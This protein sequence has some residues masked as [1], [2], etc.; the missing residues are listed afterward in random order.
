MKIFKIPSFVRY[1]LPNRTWNFK[2]ESKEIFLTFDDGPEPN[3]TPWVL[4]LLAAEGIQ[5][6][7][8]CLGKNVK[9]NP[10]LFER[11]LNEGHGIGNHT[12]EHAAYSRTTEEAY[13]K[14]IVDARELIPSNLFRPPYGKLSNKMARRISKNYQIIMWSWMAYDFDENVS[15]QKI[16]KQTK[17]IKPGDILVF[18]DNV[19]SAQR[20]KILLPIIISSLKKSGFEF[21]TITL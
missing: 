11:I 7:F 16:L 12:M 5:A 17:K 1:F 3:L 19:K 8:F 21:R 9:S 14:S 13:L 15:I 6:T 20:M 10:E 4:D 2:V 18:H